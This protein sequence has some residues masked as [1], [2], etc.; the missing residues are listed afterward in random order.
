LGLEP[1]PINYPLLFQVVSSQQPDYLG[2]PTELLYM[3]PENWMD[4][5]CQFF[6]YPPPDF[7][8]LGLP[9]WSWGL[10]NY[11]RRR[12][13]EQ[14]FVEYDIMD[15]ITENGP[16]K[17]FFVSLVLKFELKLCFLSENFIF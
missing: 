13:P 11:K 7:T 1:G 17:S 15:I 9:P 14:Q 3:I 12:Y 4:N 6:L 5:R 10:I 8:V 2:N 16:G